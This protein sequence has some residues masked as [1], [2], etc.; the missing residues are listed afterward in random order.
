MDGV[1]PQGNQYQGDGVLDVHDILTKY[2]G[3][4]QGPGDRD[5]EGEYTYLTHGVELE[6]L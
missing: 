1:Y 5:Y 4:E 2:Q 6:Y 3:G